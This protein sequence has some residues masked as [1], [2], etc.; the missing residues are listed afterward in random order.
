MLV[1]IFLLSL[2]LG[3][4][5]SKHQS[6]SPM[7]H[8]PMIE[9]KQHKNDKNDG[10]SV[11]HFDEYIVPN[12]PAPDAVLTSSGFG[13]SPAL[14]ATYQKYLASGAKDNI[15]GEGITTLAYSPYGSPLMTCAPLQLCQII[16][17]KGEVVQ[18]MAAGDPTRWQLATMTVGDQDSG[19]ASM[20]IT[21]KPN[22]EK[23]STTLTITTDK[24]L[25]RFRL[26]ADKTAE[27]PTVNFWYPRR[28]VKAKYTRLSKAGY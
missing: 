28:Y 20:I 23:M 12:N 19:D 15:E 24:R 3:G 8:H 21:V 9:A 25:Y 2:L 13:N 7:D 1:R 16:L 4:C 22:A 14:V 10:T 18:D 6:F 27:S 5:A 17:E 11:A 26:L